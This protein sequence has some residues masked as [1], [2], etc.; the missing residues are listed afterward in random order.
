MLAA[1]FAQSLRWGLALAC[2][3]ICVPA[4]ADD[5]S[6]GQSVAALRAGERTALLSGERVERPLTL[7]GERGRSIGGVAYQ[8]VHGEPARV[9][10][11]LLEVE[12]LPQMLP[13]TRS[14]RL[15]SREGGVARVELEQGVPPFVARY[16]ILL[17]PVEGR[18]ELRFWLDPAAPH[19]IRDVWGFFRVEAFGPNQTLLTAAAAV[20]LGDGLLSRLFEPRVQALLL[21]SVSAIRDYLEPAT[22]AVAPE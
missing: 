15:V 8:V 12:R 13:H 16:T 3:V 11:T 14:A 17:A 10:S 9:V 20:D 2:A 1:V 6:M 7:A 21:R 5:S 4:R 18:D 22:L 19:D